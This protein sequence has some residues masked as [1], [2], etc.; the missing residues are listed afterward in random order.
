[1]NRLT[2]WV[3]GTIWWY[4]DGNHYPAEEMDEYNTL[5]AMRK[6][7]R[8]EDLEEEGRLIK[9]PCAEGDIVW[10]IVRQR[11]SFDDRKYWL[12]TQT[13]FKLDHLPLLGKWV[14]LTQDEAER[15]IKKLE[16]GRSKK[17]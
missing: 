10:T 14:F 16:G 15:A 6:L 17:K 3:G 12:A 1:M 11:D 13:H 9:L 4:A 2:K 7:A 8:C 5:V